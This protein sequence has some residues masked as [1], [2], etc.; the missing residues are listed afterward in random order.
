MKRPLHWLAGGH[1]W[2]SGDG[3]GHGRRR[4][5]VPQGVT[6]EPRCESH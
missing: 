5:M 2:C 6:G 3:V 4:A 1:G